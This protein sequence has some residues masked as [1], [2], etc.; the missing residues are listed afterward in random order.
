MCQTE[1]YS[2][3]QFDKNLSDTFPIKK[4]SKQG[5]ALSPL[6]VNVALE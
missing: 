1:T 4:G 5:V 3:V 2:R 6:L